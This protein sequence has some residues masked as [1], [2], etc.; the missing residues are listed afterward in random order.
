MRPIARELQ[1]V[2]NHV[3]A[4]IDY[5]VDQLVSLLA[6]L[7]KFR[8]VN[9]Y[10]SGEESEE[11]QCQQYVARVLKE[12]GYSVHLW[13]PQPKNLET[14]YSGKPGFV[15]GHTFER[16]P[17]LIA[18]SS[19]KSNGPS[20]LLTGHIDVV[21]ANEADWFYPPFEGVVK[22]GRVFGRGTVDM[23]GGVAAMLFALQAIKDAAV[24]LPGQIWFS[25]V[26]DEEAGGMGTLAL[27]D[28]I[29]EK[30]LPIQ[31]AIIGEP[32]DLSLATL[33]R[34]I[35]WGEVLVRGRSGHIEVKQPH[36]RQ[37]GAVDAIKK[38]LWIYTAIERLNDEW[39]KDPRKS[40][41]LLPRPCRVEIAQIIGGHSPTSFAEE[42]KIVINVQYLPRE[43]DAAG[44]GTKV[45]K[46]IEQFIVKVSKA[47]PWLS[48]GHVQIR[49]LIDADS[50]EISA[51]HPFVSLCIDSLR[52]IK[53]PTR[54]QG[55]ETH[56]DAGL[57]GYTGQIPT[58]I[59]GPGEMRLAHQVNE[60]VNV[61]DLRAAAKF[62]AAVILLALSSTTNK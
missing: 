50:Y 37:G 61:S 1:A 5:N 51:D 59:F 46:E 4:T 35:L 55:V 27:V 12:L 22:R 7:I 31:Y 6:D 18:Q 49:W 10:L 41:P 57:L 34:G 2:I 40:H 33:S 32:T 24:D 19:E 9:P 13:E 20:I 3:A 11:L 36:W 25:T 26:V 62:Y 42:C 15:P 52:I 16:R 48:S 14:K 43:R 60:Y 17:N 45:Q 21:P 38:M 53:L 30:K 44:K 47:D 28:Y 29:L 23:K 54:L 8:T 56:T 39:E 58:I